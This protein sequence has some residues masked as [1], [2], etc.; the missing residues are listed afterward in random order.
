MVTEAST[1]WAWQKLHAQPKTTITC[2][3]Y[4]TCPRLAVSGRGGSVSTREGCSYHVSVSKQL[5]VY[6]H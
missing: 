6:Q 3:A 2:L 5:Q 4:R 1:V